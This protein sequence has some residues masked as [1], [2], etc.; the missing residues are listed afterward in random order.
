MRRRVVHRRGRTGGEWEEATRVL[1]VGS[2][3]P[4]AGGAGFEWRRQQRKVVM[5]RGMRQWGRD[6]IDRPT[7]SDDSGWEV[8]RPTSEEEARARGGVDP[9]AVLGDANDGGDVAGVGEGGVVHA[10]AR[11][12]ENYQTKI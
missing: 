1:P 12:E 2:S 6:D 9:L 7:R 10:V 3:Q 8:E 11:G 4:Q 5:W